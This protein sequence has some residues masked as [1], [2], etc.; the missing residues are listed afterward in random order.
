[1]LSSVKR[2]AKNVEQKMEE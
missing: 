1:S 2:N